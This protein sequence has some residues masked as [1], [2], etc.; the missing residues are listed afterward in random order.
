M[1]TVDRLLQFWRFYKVKPHVATGATVLDVGC[2]D[3]SLYHNIPGIKRYVGIDSCANQIQ[4]EENFQIIQGS[5]PNDLPS[6]LGSFDNVI[7]LAILEHIPESD[8]QSMARRCFD[9][10]KPGGRLLITVPEPMVDNI[11][12]LLQRLRLIDG[13]DL[14]LEE[15]HAFDTQQVP[16]IFSQ[17][18]F[19][20]HTRSKFQ[21]GLNNLFVFERP[22]TA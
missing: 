8:Y 14:G 9:L 20:E 1:K 22:L 11:L 2:A 7:M 6:N 5:F 21:L 15:H 3:A 17:V 10:L 16:R 18:G 19:H 12:H 13:Y 4:T